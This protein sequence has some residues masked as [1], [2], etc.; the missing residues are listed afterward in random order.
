[1][2]KIKLPT[3]N[4][5]QQT[6]KVNFWLREEAQRFWTHLNSIC[7]T[8]MFT[9]RNRNKI[10]LCDDKQQWSAGDTNRSKTNRI[11]I[12]IKAWIRYFPLPQP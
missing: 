4:F 11:E 2:L 6:L 9:H 12:E 7:D 1:M 5:T 10:C 8:R 3:E